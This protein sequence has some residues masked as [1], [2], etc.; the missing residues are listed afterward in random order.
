MGLTD[1]TRSIDDTMNQAIRDGVFP[2]AALL[3]CKQGEIVLRQFYGSRSLIPAPEPVTEDTLFDIASLT[4]PVATGSLALAAIQEKRLSLDDRLAR[5][6][7]DIPEGK[8]PITI[9]HLLAHTSGL[10]DWKP[11]YEIVARE[12]PRSRGKAANRKYFQPK[13]LNEPLAAGVGEKR[14]YSDLGYLLLGFLLEDTYKKPLD[15]LFEEKIARPLDLSHTSY[16][17]IGQSRPDAV[18]AATEN[19]AWRKKLIVGEVHDD[20]AYMLGGVAGHA[21]LFST[22]DD[23]HAFLSAFEV[24][25]R[26]GHRLF[27]Q[28]AVLK[29]VGAERNIKLGWDT[30]ALENSQAGSYFS[31]NSIGHL[32][33]TGCSMW[34]DLEK[35]FH[36][37]LLTN[38]V[39]PSAQNDRI[40]E[41]RPKIHGL[42][43]ETLLRP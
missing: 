3:V 19:S 11:Y 29:F 28:D 35:D 13:I 32:G 34:A 39:H 9:A 6:F 23:L 20:N 1:R 38:R 8:K 22:V 17:P 5:Y 10:P 41:F 14:I 40:K 27:S 7:G 18:C 16:L 2:G 31:K 42:L 24:G 12:H 4:K 37:I 33:Y 43:N 21:G 26:M 15:L 30:P 25:Y 36:V